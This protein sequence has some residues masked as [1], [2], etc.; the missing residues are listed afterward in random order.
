MAQW[1]NSDAASNSVLWGPELFNRKANTANRDALYG[2]TT[3]GAFVNNAIVG[4]YGVDAVEMGVAAGNVIQGFVVLP[5]SGYTANATVTFNGGGGGTSAVANAQSNSIGRIAAVNITTRGSGY[6]SDP[7]ITISPPTAIAFSGNTLSVN[8]TSDF[9]TLGANAAFL[10]NGDL[11]TYNVAAGNTAIGGLTTN[12][13]YFVFGAN[14]TAIQLAT[15]P[16]GPAIDLT[17]VPTTAQAGHSVTGQTA[18]GAVVT[19]TAKV[20]GVA[21][22]GW[23]TRTVGTGGRAGRVTTEVLVAMGSMTGDGSD[24]IVLPDA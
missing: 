20:V 3:V 7:T 22:A 21:H 1:S 23:I 12:T 10:A 11:V 2:N 24:D 4:T 13:T 16:T 9:I 14:S 8:A 17:T 15:Q 5:G 19:N 6:T 18:T